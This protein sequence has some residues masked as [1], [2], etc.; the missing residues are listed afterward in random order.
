MLAESKIHECIH[1]RH[2][3]SLRW[4]AALVEKLGEKWLPRVPS[5]L[6]CIE[7]KLN[8][9]KVHSPSGEAGMVATNHH[10]CQTQGRCG[11]E[12]AWCEEDLLKDNVGEIHP[13]RLLGHHLEV[14]VV[15]LKRDQ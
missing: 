14:E 9:E 7:R 11:E 10:E 2:V 1:L 3:P 8:Q 5:G 13:R 4:V 12:F 15:R 6:Q